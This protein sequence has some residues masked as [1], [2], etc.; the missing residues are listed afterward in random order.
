M[1]K[2][3]A[4]V[5][6]SGGLNSAV[7]AKVAAA[8]YSIALLHV[9][10]PH[11]ASGREAASVERIVGKLNPEKH[12]TLEM[13]H[14]AKIGGNARVSKRMQIEDAMAI[15]ESGAHTYIPGLIGTLVGAAFNWADVIRASRIVI[16]V[17]EELGPP[18][19]RLATIYPDHSREF[20]EITRQAYEA[21][22][23]NRRVTLE[24]PLID[25]KRAEI[26]KLGLRVGAPFADTW[27]CLS[28]NDEACGACIGCATRNRG[29]A[30][31][32]VPDPLFCEAAVH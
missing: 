26:I 3:T 28:N 27:S 18:A 31:A 8:E 1:A 32:G 13:Q 16:G 24:M 22:S 14:F 2:E 17:T 29:F 6:C 7:A 4:V 5:L 20:L 12:L 15:G 9:S 30:E 25:L 21:A 23:P 11:R 10:F 19:P